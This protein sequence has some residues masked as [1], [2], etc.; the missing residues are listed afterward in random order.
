M[1]QPK[2]VQEFE[3]FV[4][5]ER[6]GL[7]RRD[8]LRH[9][10][11]LGLSIPAASGV[12]ATILGAPA[13][14]FAQDATEAAT[15]MAAKGGQGTLVAEQS[16]D[17]VSFNPDYTIDD[18][19]YP[20]AFNTHSML[21]TLNQ[22]VEVVPDLAETWE[23]SDDGLQITFH[24]V[25]NAMWHD[26]KPVTSADVK[27]TYEKIVA[28]EG[29]PGRDNM[30]MLDHI[31]TPDDYTAVFVLKTPSSQFLGFLA[32]YATFVLPK[33][34]YDGTDWSTN[35]VNQKP[36][37]SGPFKFVEY[38]SGDHVT[39]EA[40]PDYYAEGPYLDRVV[41]RIIPDAATL[42]QAMLNDEVDVDI[43][44][45]FPTDSLPNIEKDGRFTTVPKVYASNLYLV[46]NF[47]RE[48]TGKLEVRKAIGEAINR[49]EIIERGLSGAGS[50]VNTYYTPV[51]AWANNT[52]A[53]APDFN[54]ED[55]KKLLDAAGYPVKADGYRFKLSFPYLAF[56]D[57]WRSTAQVIQAQLRAVGID[58]DLV[59]LEPSAWN[60]RVSTDDNYDISYLGGFL[61]PGPGAL[62]NRYGTGGGI[63][64]WHYSNADVDKLLDEAA[65]DP[66]ADDATAK[67]K[68]VQALLA[69]DIASI[70]FSGAAT[71]FVYRKELSGFSV[72]GDPVGDILGFGNFAR[73]QRAAE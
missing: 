3:A 41:Y 42:E 25:K 46:F 56:G 61:G 69:K 48:I 68:Q 4:R 49:A 13:R 72:P 15:E 64:F 67:Y 38:V 14:V 47:G 62:K 10:L 18:Y 19:G 70:P 2:K 31:N 34:L 35:P 5:S 23:T 55:S 44:G 59:E 26:G 22:G 63:N 65:S 1:D 33:H 73:V 7:S 12:I 8:F 9:G 53:T 57:A 21:V 29:A 43:S 37:G 52:D 39:L 45:I 60:A 32:W 30:V 40:N 16:G 36:I 71:T 51:I 50:P 20:I 58:T 17:P 66:S 6:K 28:T 11:A 27:W 54:I 24:L